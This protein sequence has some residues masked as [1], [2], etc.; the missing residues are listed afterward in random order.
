MYVHVYIANKNVIFSNDTINVSFVSNEGGGSDPTT[1][2]PAEA[3]QRLNPYPFGIDP[4]SDDGVHIRC[5]VN[6]NSQSIR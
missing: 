3:M 4:V 2:L 5:L 1:D 6:C